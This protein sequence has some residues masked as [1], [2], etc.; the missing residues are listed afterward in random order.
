[1]IYKSKNYKW[2]LSKN[3]LEYL[4][5]EEKLSGEK[6]SKMFNV[7]SWHISQLRKKYDIKKIECWQRH[8]APIAISK[9]E[10]ELILGYVLGDGYIRKSSIHC[11][12]RVSQSQKQEKFVVQM[13]DCL[14]SW[15]AY[16]PVV[17]VKY[18]NRCNK[19][20]STY[21]FDTIAHPVFDD[22]RN[23]CYKEGVKT[24]TNEWLNAIGHLG[25][26]MWYQ[27]DGHIAGGKV[28]CVLNTNGFSYSEHEVIVD[29][30][31][32][33]LGIE[34]VIRKHS[35]YY[36]IHIIDGYKFCQLIKSHMI[37]YFDYKLANERQPASRFNIA[38][39]IL[40][41]DMRKNGMKHKEIAA[42]FNIS[43]SYVCEILNDKM[44]W[45]VCK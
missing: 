15:A 21:R 17:D 35:K 13:Y 29:W 27:G 12:L 9:E 44:K 23:I 38:D 26:A 24:V 39:K 7:S 40:M 30:F 10:K 42:K 19:E 25:L 20:Y 16:Y 14:K 33:T 45:G 37:P 22:L 32:K 28:T 41:F 36:K 3:N 11:H 5:C 2:P 43:S 34:A 4:Y 6:I 8:N 31:D 18:D 1:M